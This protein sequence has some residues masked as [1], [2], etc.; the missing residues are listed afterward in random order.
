VSRPIIIFIFCIL[1]IHIYQIG[2]SQSFTPINYTVES[3]LPSNEVYDAFQDRKGFIWFA[4][5][6]GVV[7]YDG[8][9]M[10]NFGIEDGLTDQ[11]VF[12]FYEDYRGR[13]WFRTYSGKISFYDNGKIYPYMYND[14]LVK[15]TRHSI[16]SNIHIDSLDQLWFSSYF[17]QASWGKIDRYGNV[18]KSILQ[19]KEAYY[20]DKAGFQLFGN[21]QYKLEKLLI[22]KT[23]ISIDRE[24]ICSSPK[25]L[26]I[27]WKGSTYLAI[28][29][30]IF[31]LKNS[32]IKKV[33]AGVGYIISLSKDRQDNLWIGYLSHGAQ[34]I[35]DTTFQ[36]DSVYFLSTLSVSE[37]LSDHENGLWMS[38]LEKGIFYTPNLSIKNNIIGDSQIQHIAKSSQYVYLAT[39]DGKVYCLDHSGKIKSARTFSPPIGGLYVDKTEN[40][41]ISENVEGKFTHCFDRSLQEAMSTFAFSFVNVAEERDSTLWFVGGSLQIVK[42]N[43][44]KKGENSVKSPER[45]NKILIQ[46]SLIF[47]SEKSGLH[48]VSILTLKGEEVRQLSNCKINSIISLNDSILLLTTIARGFILYNH[49]TNHIDNYSIA[50]K[51]IADNVYSVATQGEYLWMGTE[52]GLVRLTIRSLFTQNLVYQILTSKGGLPGNQIEHIAVDGSNV[53]AVSDNRFSIIDASSITFTYGRPIFYFKDFKVNNV[54]VPIDKEEIQLGYNEN[55][56]QI[57]FGFIA[58]N[59]NKIFVRYRLNAENDWHYLTS[60]ILQLYS[61]GSGSYS[62]ELQYSIDNVNWSSATGLPQFVILPPLWKTWYFQT[63]IGLSILFL[64][65]FYFRS[66]MRIYKR[67]QQKLMILEIEAVEKE[68]SRIAKDLH[69][70]V[71]TD[72]TAIKMRVSQILKVMDYPEKNEVEQQFQHTIQE[73]KG[74]IYDLSPPGLERYGLMA[75]FRNY[76]DRI[77]GSIPI[78]INL[79]TFGNEVK[80]MNV[81]IAVFRVVQELISNSLKHSNA[82]H[83]NLH[84]NAFDDLLNIVYEDDGKGFSY[85]SNHKGLGLYSIES[86]VQSIKGQLKFES[87]SFGISYSIDIPLS[88]S[89]GNDIS[90]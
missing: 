20:L 28:C 37:V 78:K 77:N 62:L 29:N 56:I 80:N 34:R 53:W 47:I 46:D 35:S 1:S 63:V 72:F 26:P 64:I 65:F 19:E 30:S 87:G 6:N 61:L 31:E 51:F 73:I 67:H 27:K 76:V 81:S 15:A 58:F 12:G 25:I 41:W 75:G 54:E 57:D 11:T 82:Q 13:I 23:I 66:Q 22:N 83:I 50:N 21:V 86:R 32:G 70:S 69:D 90:K 71:G 89:I 68:R 33:F 45:A 24:T 52:S 49:V 10:K 18:S 36:S 55:D 5:D 3:G 39:D 88:M 7:K 17:S 60:R 8:F 43:R 9:E 85:D 14:S 38:T 59:N 42:V 79:N 48:K 84:I 74:I 16:I 40:V 4:T 2:N 44:L